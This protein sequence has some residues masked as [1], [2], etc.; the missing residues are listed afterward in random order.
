MKI[1]ANNKIYD[2]QNDKSL[3]FVVQS[4][5]KNITGGTRSYEM[6]ISEFK[7]LTENNIY[8]AREALATR[9]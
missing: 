5:G 8:A 7:R 1:C 9:G 2:V 4:N 3:G 6:A